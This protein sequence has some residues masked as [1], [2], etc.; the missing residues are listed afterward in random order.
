MSEPNSLPPL[1]IKARLVLDEVELKLRHA[2]SLYPPMHSVH[3]GY[4]I[5]LE[6]LDELWQEIK[7]K[8]LY[9]SEEKLRKEALQVAAMAVRFILDTLPEGE[10]F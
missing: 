4:S 7:L 2:L 5:I 3:E 6:E 1:S 10:E 9:R 8:S